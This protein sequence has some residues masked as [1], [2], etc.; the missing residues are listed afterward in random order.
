MGYPMSPK[1]C[2]CFKP[3]KEHDQTAFL[4]SLSQKRGGGTNKTENKSG[5][6]KTFCWKA[7]NSYHPWPA[8]LILPSISISSSFQSVTCT[9]LKVSTRTPLELPLK[10]KRKRKEE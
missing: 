4:S 7:P 9:A 6:A 5:C 8:A 3:S 2:P 1:A 10:L